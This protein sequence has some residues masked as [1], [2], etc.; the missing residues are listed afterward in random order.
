MRVRLVLALSLAF[1]PLPA[2]AVDCV[3]LAVGQAPFLCG[4]TFS[5]ATS[6]GTVGSNSTASVITFQNLVGGPADNFSTAAGGMSGG[7]RVDVDWGVLRAFANADNGDFTVYAPLESESRV[8]SSAVAAFADIAT[9][10]SN[11]LPPGTPVAITVTMN[12]DGGFSVGG[13][14]GQ[15]WLTYSKVSNFVAFY[16][17][18]QA[19]LS[20]STNFVP[21]PFALEGYTVG[22][23][24]IFKFAMRANAGTTNRVNPP[25]TGAAA[26]ME[27]TGLLQIEV[28]TPGVTLEALSGH[29]YTTVPEPSRALLLAAAG[30]VLAARSRSSIGCSTS[31]RSPR[32]A[33]PARSCIRH[34]GFPVAIQ[35]GSTSARAS[36]FRA[37]TARD[38]SP[39]VR[40]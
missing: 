26:N 14:G 30:V 17:E 2:A 15:A 35:S 21:P 24:L 5:R 3:S 34:P 31:A 33:A 32:S 40:L 9:L 29:D 27:N 7:A 28:T 19:V 18:K 10:T 22:D 8:I 23:Q 36:I 37:S 20:Y 12:V 4:E 38:I 13:S 11:T 6:Q 1:A 39:W 25:V 16:M